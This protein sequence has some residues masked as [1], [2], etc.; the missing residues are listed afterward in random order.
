LLLEFVIHENH[1]EAA[2]W[3]AL[4]HELKG[5]FD[6]VV[7]GDLLPFCSLKLHVFILQAGPLVSSD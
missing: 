3:S 5:K 1:E 6:E 2:G 4:E 7:A